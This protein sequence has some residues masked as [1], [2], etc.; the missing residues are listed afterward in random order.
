MFILFVFFYLPNRMIRPSTMLFPSPQIARTSFHY[1]HSSSSKTLKI[2]GKDLNTVNGRRNSVIQSIFT[3]FHQK[4]ILFFLKKFYPIPNLKET[5]RR[6]HK[7]VEKKWIVLWK[8][9]SSASFR[10]YK[11]NRFW[12]KFPNMAWRRPVKCDWKAGAAF[13]DSSPNREIVVFLKKE[14]RI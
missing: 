3:A 14:I 12:N 4:S 10:L 9:R 13:C 7:S 6:N 1:P 2:F 8:E 5:Q 11:L